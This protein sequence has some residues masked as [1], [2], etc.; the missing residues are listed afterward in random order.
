[1]YSTGGDFRGA[2]YIERLDVLPNFKIQR[3][4][5][6]LL[7]I[8]NKSGY[9]GTDTG[10]APCN[11]TDGCIM[12]KH[13]SLGYD[14]GQINAS[15][16]PMIFKNKQTNIQKAF[17]CLVSHI[18]GMEERNGVIT[19]KKS[20]IEDAIADLYYK[21]EYQKLIDHKD[22]KHDYGVCGEYLHTDG[23][24]DITLSPSHTPLKF[25]KIEAR[26]ISSVIERPQCLSHFISGTI[27]T[28]TSLQ[29]FLN[30]IVLC[31]HSIWDKKLSLTASNINVT[32][33][34][35]YCIKH[36]INKDIPNETNLQDMINMIVL[37]LHYIYYELHPTT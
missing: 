19:C 3:D 28:T 14:N 20:F 21:I 31:F 27:P 30:K 12:V 36:F 33:E 26:E 7:L 17:D 16:I 9:I 13:L 6:R 2:L 23:N 10:W 15:V 24:L 22:I 35:P 11:L 34:R 18:I 5:G 32:I 29:D 4:I 8:K 25:K 37:C 1:M